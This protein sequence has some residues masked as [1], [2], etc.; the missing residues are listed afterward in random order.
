MELLIGVPHGSVL[1]LLLVN[2]Y[3]NDLFFLTESRNVCSYA[4]DTTFHACD[5]DLES[6]V[7]RCLSLS[8][9]EVII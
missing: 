2:I 5:M 9:L 6:L 1:G 8:G 3:I 4:D 7:R